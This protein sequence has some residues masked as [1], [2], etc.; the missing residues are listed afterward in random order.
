MSIKTL[1]WLPLYAQ[2]AA[3]V[4]SSSAAAAQATTLGDTLNGGLLDVDDILQTYLHRKM[5]FTQM[6]MDMLPGTRL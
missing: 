6:W 3:A 1:A 2:Y 5:G 4:A